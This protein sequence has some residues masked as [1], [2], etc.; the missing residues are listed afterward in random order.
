MCQDFPRAYE[1]KGVKGYVTP[2]DVVKFLSL[3]AGL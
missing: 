3:V 1:G 2:E